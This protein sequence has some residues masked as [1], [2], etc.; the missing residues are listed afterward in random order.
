[1]F[2]IIPSCFDFDAWDATLITVYDSSPHCLTDGIVVMDN[3][4]SSIIG[5]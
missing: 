4:N 3:S 1:M 2:D 5:F